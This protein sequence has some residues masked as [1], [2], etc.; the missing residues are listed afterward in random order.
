MLKFSLINVKILILVKYSVANVLNS[1]PNQRFKFELRIEPNYRQIS[2]SNS[3]FFV[4]KGED[5]LEEPIIPQNKA[6]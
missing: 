4:R 3:I 1:L 2:A 6:E 5:N